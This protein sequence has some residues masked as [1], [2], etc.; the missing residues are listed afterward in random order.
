MKYK[1]DIYLLEVEVDGEVIEVYMPSPE[2]EAAR[3]LKERSG[4]TPLE[5]HREQYNGQRMDRI[6]DQQFRWGEP[7]RA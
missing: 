1:D 4:K 2:E 5:I 6:E 7:R 3:L